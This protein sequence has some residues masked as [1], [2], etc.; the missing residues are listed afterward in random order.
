MSGSAWGR[1]RSAAAG[2]PYGSRHVSEAVFA[3]QLV[4]TAVR[5]IA[6]PT[7]QEI[8]AGRSLLR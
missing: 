2:V 1:F 8:D 3:A 6:A 7:I 5:S 4:R